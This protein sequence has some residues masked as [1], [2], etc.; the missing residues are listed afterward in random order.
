MVAYEEVLTA[1]RA[2]V[3]RFERDVAVQV[4]KWQQL[5]VD[6]RKTSET[7][8]R[9]L[10]EDGELLQELQSEVATVTEELREWHNLA[11]ETAK[12]LKIANADVVLQTGLQE[13]TQEEM[14]AQTVEV[15]ELQEQL[16][17]TNAELSQLPATRGERND[18]LRRM[19]LHHASGAT[20]SGDL[21]L[22]AGVCERPEKRAKMTRLRE[23][24]S[25]TLPMPAFSA[26]LTERDYLQNL[27]EEFT[28]NTRV[29]LGL[30]LKRKSCEKG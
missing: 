25:S 8:S 18:E 6:R 1:K 7:A 24:S 17:S 20:V 2:R 3:K 15:A 11:T 5:L 16:V 19:K 14:D 4:E 26:L 22:V 29:F 28:V 13:T 12:K 10:A 21:M 30:P 23:V 27:F 9:Q